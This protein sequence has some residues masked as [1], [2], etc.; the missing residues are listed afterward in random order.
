M[1][2]DSAVTIAVVGV[3]AT[4]VG[5][6]LWIIKFLFNK[7]LPRIEEG[8]LALGKLSKSTDAN[9][10]ATKSADKYLQERNGRDAEIHEELVTAINAIPAQII[11]TAHITAKT[12][13]DTP[14]DQHIKT[15]TVDKQT[16]NSKE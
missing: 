1:N 10:K 2:P 14:H 12:L 13:A 3:L 8:N 5:G 11:K 6:L 7:L 9:T 16:V 4:C 15:Q